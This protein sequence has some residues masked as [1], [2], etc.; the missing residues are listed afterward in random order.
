MA[1]GIKC[2]FDFLNVLSREKLARIQDGTLSILQNTGVKIM[3]RPTLELLA[4]QGVQ[5]D[6][7]REV[8][9][10]SEN[11]IMDSLAKAP[12]AFTLKA[13]EQDS[14]CNFVSGGSIIMTTAPGRHTV[15][16]DTWETREPT[17]KELYD[18]MRVVD[19]LE[20][21]DMACAFPWAGLA[22]VPECMG[23][24][25]ILAAKIR[26]STKGLWEG[27]LMDNYLF[28]TKLAQAT[29]VDLWHNTNPTSP[30]TF[31]KE[32]VEQI[33]HLSLNKQVFSIT[34]GPLLGASAPA[35]IAGA[36]A[37][38]N[39]DILAANAIAQLY[40]P[41]TRT[42]AGGMILV[43]DMRTA[44]PAFA[45]AGGYLAESAFSQIWRNYGLPSTSNSPGWS[46]SKMIDYQAAYETTMGAVTMAFSGATAIAF[47]G[48]LTAELSGHPV[49]A[50]I[51][52]DIIGMIKRI[53]QGIDVDDETLACEL[54][55]EVGFA[56]NTYLA[57]EHTVNWFA[58]ESFMPAVADRLP[59]ENWLAGGKKSLVDHGRERMA[60]ILQKH[61]QKT[62]SATQE[63][64]IEDVLNEAR[65]YYRKT[66]AI[67][68]T[69]WKEYQASIAS[70]NY[71]YA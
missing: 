44:T 40:Q 57:E 53:L 51:D 7:A 55:D 1:K 59:L 50:I 17:R 49:K 54:I 47:A 67:S 3:H 35:T 5:V 71:P 10:M 8:A 46:N 48:A 70:P 38:N 23:L 6:F 63:Q 13:R 42:L 66:G 12:S 39:A 45:N 21:V 69:Q 26:V 28:N 20:H 43:L 60:E 2:D 58:H 9:K 36:L 56:P 15:D 18:Y 14:D 65:T 29:G 41:G 34:S 31:Y 16:L 33:K 19:S 68:D 27:S 64:S 24:I 62:L 11:F 4:E 30:L 32:S 25:E 61:K 37:L 52:N 22:G